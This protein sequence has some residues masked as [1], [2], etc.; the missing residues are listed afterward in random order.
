MK[1]YDI[2]AYVWP[3]Y[4][5]DES[6]TRMFWDEG[7]GEWQTVKNSKPKPCGYNWGRSPLWGYVN[8]A[9]P[10]VMEMQINAASDHGVN[11]FI[12]DWYWYDNRPFLENCLN[13]GFLKAS[14]CNKMKFYI[15]WAN[16]DANYLWDIRNSD[17][18]NET[19]WQGAVDRQQFETI[20]KRWIEQYFTKENYYKIDGKPVVSIYDMNNFV[21]G[22]GG[23]EN[24]LDAMNWLRGQA[25]ENGL[26]GVHF[27]FVRWSGTNQNITGVDGNVTE[28]TPELVEAMGFDSLTHYQ[29]VHFVN[30]DRDYTEIIPEVVKEWEKIHKQY[31]IPYFPHVSVGWDNNPRF[32]NFRKGVV[33]NNTPENFQKALEDAKKY[34][35]K[36]NVSLIT[37]NSWNEW[38][39]T[40]Y[41]E[42]DNVYG[43][44]YLD[45]IR[46]VFC[47]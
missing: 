26:D 33:K 46:N 9:D 18:V 6:R 44:G 34:A 1:K 47:E 40:S 29:F 23:V 35:D 13:D 20:G 3:A 10:Y 38:T 28:T 43:Y 37:I 5:G 7:I 14:N 45:A 39:E 42:P 25:M 31:N 36:H 19:I 17:T 4:T 8:E 32:L 16:H 12:Y 27:Q 21:S 22:L 30:I 15:M 24:A 11:V 2:A 41:L